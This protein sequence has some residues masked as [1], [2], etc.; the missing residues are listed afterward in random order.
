MCGSERRRPE[1]SKHVL[2]V[3]TTAFSTLEM[4]LLLYPNFA[5][6]WFG[7]VFSVLT[8]YPLIFYVLLYIIIIFVFFQVLLHITVS[9]SKICKSIGFFCCFSFISLDCPLD[10][11]TMP[12]IYWNILQGLGQSSLL[13]TQKW[14]DFYFGR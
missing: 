1:S 8:L 9:R 10:S 13:R 6:E 4:V 12:L 5:W 11:V 3:C 14:R 7:P 2:N